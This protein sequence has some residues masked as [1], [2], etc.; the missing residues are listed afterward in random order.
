MIQTDPKK[1]QHF[2]NNYSNK[3]ENNAIQNNF[4]LR[5]LYLSIKYTECYT[6]S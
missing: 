4:S 1:K 6:F 5:Y 2:S 3:N